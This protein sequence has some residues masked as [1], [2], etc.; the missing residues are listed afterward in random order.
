MRS[1][2]LNKEQLRA[3]TFPHPLSVV[4]LAK[5]GHA[6]TTP[7]SVLR[8]LYVVSG[9]WT[10]YI[11]TAAACEAYLL[12]YVSSFSRLTFF[13]R[14]GFRTTPSHDWR[15]FLALCSGINPRST[16]KIMRAGKGQTWVGCMQRKLHSHSTR[17]PDSQYVFRSKGV[18]RVIF[19]LI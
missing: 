3:S 17:S 2:V 1:W 13:F 14:F 11:T 8:G 5:P 10:R 12:Y 6:W 16:Q 9:I 18:T 4:Q 19:I 15:L 7:D